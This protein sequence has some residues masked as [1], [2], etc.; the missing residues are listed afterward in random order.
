MLIDGV[1]AGKGNS[2]K[3]RFRVSYRVGQERKEEQGM[4]P[5]LGIA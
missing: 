5:S 4:V 2:I 1:D 3:M